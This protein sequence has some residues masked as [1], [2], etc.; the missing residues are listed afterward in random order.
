MISWATHFPQDFRLHQKDNKMPPNA[1]MNY[2]QTGDHVLSQYFQLLTGLMGQI[3][4]L[5]NLFFIY[6]PNHSYMSGVA[7]YL[8]FAFVLEGGDFIS[9]LS[10][11]IDSIRHSEK[12]ETRSTM[13]IQETRSLLLG[14]V[15]LGE[16]ELA[17]TISYSLA[18][19]NA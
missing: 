18:C 13:G 17:S 8:H 12:V 1:P 11:L 3:T 9:S 14:M 2:I 5:L 19:V 10:D 4:F 15:V 7:F 16:D 6:F